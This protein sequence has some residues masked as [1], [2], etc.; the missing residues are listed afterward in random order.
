MAAGAKALDDDRLLLIIDGLDEWVNE[1]TARQALTALE[2]F[3]DQ[4]AL[5]AVASTRPYGLARLQPLRTWQYATMAALSASQQRELVGRWF[6]ASD[7]VGAE[8]SS[9]SATSEAKAEAFVKE[10][11]GVR[12]LRQ[13][14]RVPLFLVLLTGM[15]LAG[16]P[17]PKRRFEV[18]A[19]A[20]DHLLHEHPAQRGAA[21]GV[22]NN[23]SV[24]HEGDIRQ[25]LA[26]V[27]L[28]HQTRGEVQ[29]VPEREALQDVVA[30]LR[31]PRHLALGPAE[32]GRLARG[33]VDIVEG[34]LGV[35][36][37]H[38]PRDIGFLHRVLL[39][40]LA[41]E[42]AA[43]QLSFDELRRCSLSTPGT[44]AGT[45]CCW[46]SCGSCAPRKSPCCWAILPGTQRDRNQPRW[47]CASYGP[48]PC[49]V[50]S[51]CLRLRLDSMP[52][53]SRM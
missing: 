19:G 41:A 52:P 29:A 1:N 25:V 7:D 31:D 15:R 36:V 17:L 14:A 34:Q 28:T 45:R 33:L 8:A 27:A 53:Q 44:R 18:Y 10:L 20:I 26:H 38:G 47:P 11:A 35:L 43:Q 32:A 12:D 48:R 5:P 40:Q 51:D 4:R 2:T 30:A 49:S 37:R 13:L 3:L 23:S 9:R 6:A 42:H 22:T 21:A 24:L 39:E 50:V 46:P 16:A